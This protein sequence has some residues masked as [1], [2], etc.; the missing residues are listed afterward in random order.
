MFHVTIF[1]QVF[2]VC[3]RLVTHFLSSARARERESENER[4][5]E[6]VYVCVYERVREKGESIWQTWLCLSI[7]RRRYCYF[8]G[9]F[10]FL[11]ANAAVLSFRFTISFCWPNSDEKKPP[12]PIFLRTSPFLQGIYRLMFRSFFLL[13]LA[14]NKKIFGSLRGL[15]PR[16][17]VSKT[18][19]IQDG[20]GRVG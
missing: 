15:N 11:G 1:C 18:N 6:C 16:F 4:K 13:Y 9:V 2:F 8:E 12:P 14:R 10:L 19:G 7:H 20:H 3:S 17:F 5:R